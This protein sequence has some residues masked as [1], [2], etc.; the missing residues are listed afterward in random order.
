MGSC[1]AFN[2]VIEG[3]SIELSP[4]CVWLSFYGF[5]KHAISILFPMSY[6]FRRERK[7]MIFSKR[8][9]SKKF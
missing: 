7:L 3:E 5:T 4:K 8:G 2:V 1:E 6:I 9:P